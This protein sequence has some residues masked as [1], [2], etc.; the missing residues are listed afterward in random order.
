MLTL[1]RTAREKPIVPL[2]QGPLDAVP[3]DY[4]REPRT[5]LVILDLERTLAPPQIYNFAPQAILLNADG[6]IL[7]VPAETE[8]LAHFLGGQ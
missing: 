5:A 2:F 3:K 1:L 8:S 4:L 7:G 6:K